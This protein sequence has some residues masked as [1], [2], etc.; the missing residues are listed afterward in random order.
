MSRKAIFEKRAGINWSDIESMLK[1]FGAEITEGDVVH[2]C[3]SL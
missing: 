2:E 3:G 1:H